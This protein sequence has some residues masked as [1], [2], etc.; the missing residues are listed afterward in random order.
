MNLELLSAFESA[1]TL[2]VQGEHPQIVIDPIRKA[3]E[4]EPGGLPDPTTDLIQVVRTEMMRQKNNC[5][6]EPIWEEIQLY[7]EDTDEQ[8]D[9]PSPQKNPRAIGEIP[10]NRF[11]AL[12]LIGWTVQTGNKMVIQ[13]TFERWTSS[14]LCLALEASLSKVSIKSS[15]KAM[16]RCYHRYRSFV[17]HLVSSLMGMGDCDTQTAANEVFARL[18]DFLERN[19]PRRESTIIEYRNCT[20]ELHQLLNEMCH[21]EPEV[22]CKAY[23]KILQTFKRR[24]SQP[25]KQIRRL[26]DQPSRPCHAL[27]LSIR[28]EFLRLVRHSLDDNSVTA[29]DALLWIFRYAIIVLSDSPFTNPPVFLLPPVDCKQSEAS[30]GVHRSLGVHRERRQSFSLEQHSDDE[31][32]IGPADSFMSAG[33]SQSEWSGIQI[34]RGQGLHLDHGQVRTVQYNCPLGCRKYLVAIGLDDLSNVVVDHLEAEHYGH[35]LTQTIT[36]DRQ[37]YPRSESYKAVERPTKNQNATVSTGKKRRHQGDGDSDIEFNQGEISK[38][39]SRSRSV[40]TD[41]YNSKYNGTSNYGS[42]DGSDDEYTYSNNGDSDSGSIDGQGNTVATHCTPSGKKFFSYTDNATQKTWHQ[43]SDCMVVLPNKHGFGAHVRSCKKSKVSLDTD[44]AEDY[45]NFLC[46]LEKLVRGADLQTVIRKI[47]CRMLEFPNIQGHYGPRACLAIENVDPNF[48]S[49]CEAV[50]EAIYQYLGGQFR[51]R[52]LGEKAVNVQHFTKVGIIALS[53]V[54]DGAITPESFDRWSDRYIRAYCAHL[55]LPLTSTLQISAS[56]IIDEAP[57]RYLTQNQS[58]HDRGETSLL[59]GYFECVK[60]LALDVALGEQADTIESTE[61]RLSQAEAMLR[62]PF[63]G[64]AQRTQAINSPAY[65][66]LL[67]YFDILH[68]KAAVEPESAYSKVYKAVIQH[69]YNKL[70][71]IVVPRMALSNV[72]LLFLA[73]W[74]TFPTVVFG[75]AH[76]SHFSIPEARSWLSRYTLISIYLFT[77]H[78]QELETQAESTSQSLRPNSAARAQIDGHRIPVSSELTSEADESR[79]YATTNVNPIAPVTSKSQKP[80]KRDSGYTECS[81]HQP[82]RKL[83]I[84]TQLKQIV[85]EYLLHGEVN[86]AS[87]KMIWLFAMCGRCMYCSETWKPLPIVSKLDELPWERELDFMAHLTLAHGNHCDMWGIKA[88]ACETCDVKL[89]TRAAAA[90][91]SLSC[92]PARIR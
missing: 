46:G 4:S 53:L 31:Q 30:E 72:H 16:Q 21:G 39:Q 61:K 6:F 56:S 63:L 62:G 87:L 54:K 69:G 26:I 89:L 13:K 15:S 81:C 45:G 42:D 20:K 59:K 14:V 67:P 70:P 82:P 10:I 52:A 28:L 83:F 18:S 40:R 7:C 43:C 48:D 73:V 37:R 91:H 76:Q 44:K 5:N 32:E 66:P 80:S 57:L 92:T 8:F 25:G 65:T 23:T 71:A 47:T 86:S 77:I 50:N 38:R 60:Q 19:F 17:I 41:S 78:D 88:G 3:C 58:K 55:K 49:H 85:L 79:G 29:S 33:N 84:D 12:I 22:E 1:L 34:S 9:E 27:R 24:I 2:L 90:N 36:L 11:A 35:P 51:G 75:L 74:F 64:S 68:D